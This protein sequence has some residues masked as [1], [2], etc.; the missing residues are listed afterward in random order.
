MD[1]NRNRRGATP[2]ETRALSH[3]L[4]LRII[5]L[6]YDEQL[7]N[8]A[9]ATRLGAHP[10]TVLHHVR[11]LVRTGFVVPAGEQPGARGTVEKL[12]RGTGK[13][14]ELSIDDDEA[15]A[16][17]VSR[18]GTEA[19]IA[20]LADAPDDVD[21]SRLALVITPERLREMETRI[22]A[23][24]DEYALHDDAGGERWAVFVAYHRRA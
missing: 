15:A 6:L 16:V 21:M 3:P 7:S 4:R 5:R 19:F 13:S 23:I 10:A 2:E 11:T 14:W 20:E 9:L 8:K 22:A 12:Y 1:V 18:A 17:R 24:L